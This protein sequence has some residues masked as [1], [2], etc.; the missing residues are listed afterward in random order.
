M[1]KGTNNPLN[2]NLSV[3]S[4]VYLHILSSYT[5]PGLP[6]TFSMAQVVFSA[7]ALPTIVIQEWSYLWSHWSFSHEK[8]MA[9]SLCVVISSDQSSAGFIEKWW[10]NSQK[11][12]DISAPKNQSF[13]ISYTKKLLHKY[14]LISVN[15]FS[16]LLTNIYSIPN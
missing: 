13:L 5:G 8:I 2:E 11:C 12:V 6:H 9:Y 14:H 3:C 7:P 1:Y 16:R 10:R 15:E 4:R